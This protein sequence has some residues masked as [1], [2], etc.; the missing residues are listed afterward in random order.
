MTLVVITL[1][2]LVIF[3]NVNEVSASSTTVST[4][5][6][7][8]SSDT[9]KNYVESKNT[10]PTTVKVDDKQVT[11]EQYLY[12][13]TS[14][15]TNL[16][17]NNKNTITVNTVAKAPNPS[18]N[19]KGSNIYKSEYI[20]LADEITTFINKNGRLPNFITT[21]LGNMRTENII[22]TYSNVV[23]FY[24]TNNRLPN[25]VTIAPWKMASGGSSTPST[26]TT[27][28][29]PTTPST[30]TSVNSATTD[31]VV[32]SSDAVKNYVESKNNVPGT[33]TVA[34][35]TITLEQ[36]LYL[37][38]S[39]ITNINQNNKNTITIKS[40]TKAPNSSENLKGGNIYKS[41][42]IK[43]AD[44][45]TTFINKNG[46][47]PNFITTSLGNMRP[48][49]IIYTYS[50]VLSFYKTNNRLP[51]YVI[52]KPWS[53]T[54]SNPS[55]PEITPDQCLSPTENAPSNNTTIINL[56]QSITNGKTTIYGKA[57]AIFNWVRDNLTYSFYYNT[58]MGALGALSN[59]TA[60]C[61]DTSHLV[62]AL[63]R[64]VGIPAKYQHGTCTFSNGTYGHVWTQLYVDGKWYD[65][66][67]ISVAN[68]FGVIKNWNTSTVKDLKT[69]ID[70]AF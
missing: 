50:N 68:S 1:L 35:K 67:A 49:N 27:P 7:V 43:L 14:T 18:E 39:S 13:L 48:E 17:K 53:V 60:N 52:V 8:N 55:I 59:R 30:P 19:L 6:V 56:A 12:L 16:N 25:Y 66:D 37:L 26:P 34:G 40:I 45:I 36:Y 21:S 51:N 44:I 11:S 62:V 3:I 29:T 31:S 58:E 54:A 2:A 69:Y 63:S 9:V 61:V 24:K 47:L 42:Y 33:V 4:N 22:Y 46:R 10:V 23:A 57:Q 5:S 41:E 38:T 32:N 70:V 64:A 15:V 20:K 65:A 28:T